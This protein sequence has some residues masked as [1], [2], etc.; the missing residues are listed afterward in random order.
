MRQ[1]AQ[2]PFE[3][4]CPKCSCLLTYAN[5]KN[6]N[7]AEKHQQQCS[8]CSAKDVS[9][10]PGF[11]KERVK[12]RRSYE[13]KDNPF[14]G[15]H[16]KLETIEY[17]KNSVDRQYT[18]TDEFR[19]KSSRAGTSNGM[20]GRNFYDVWIEKF[21]GEEADRKYAEWLSVQSKNSSGANNPM[22]GK[23]S[24]RGSGGGWGGWY[25]EWYFRSLRELSYMI[26]VIEVKKY[27]WRSAEIK[28]FDIHYVNYDGTNRTYRPDFILNEKILVEIKPK[29]LM[30]TPGNILKKEAA[31]KFC[32]KKGLEYRLVDVKILETKILI[33]LFE[34]GIIRF[35][36]KY[37]KRMKEICKQAKNRKSR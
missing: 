22:F 33:K 37:Q 28:E 31:I 12:N 25:K 4:Q 6:R 19:K 10:R 32:S 17:L 30:E 18:Q 7:R 26:S 34:D 24:P 16:H 35:N 27:K 20:F 3:R 23:P 21:G 11:N 1:K 13:G 2:P 8:S 29:R 15:K 36:K 9:S 5:V 14:F